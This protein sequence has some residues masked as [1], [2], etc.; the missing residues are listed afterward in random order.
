MSTCKIAV[1][2]YTN[3]MLYINIKGK[4]LFSY[5]K[6]PKGTMNSTFCSSEASAATLIEL[7]LYFSCDG[8]CNQ[9]NVWLTADFEKGLPIQ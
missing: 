3:F 6:V 4:N 1:Q 7:K 8:W 9:R 2:R 5:S